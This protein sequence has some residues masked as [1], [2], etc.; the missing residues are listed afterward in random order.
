VFCLLLCVEEVKK[1]IAYL[2]KNVPALD[3]TF[4]IVD[5]IGAGKYQHM[6][7]LLIFKMA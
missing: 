5:K 2:L 3:E 1:S 7:L 4:S 6:L